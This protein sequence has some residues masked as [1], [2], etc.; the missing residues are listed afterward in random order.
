LELKPSCHA[1]DQGDDDLSA[2]NTARLAERRAARL[3]T[4]AHKKGYRPAMNALFLWTMNLVKPTAPDNAIRRYFAG[5]EKN[6]GKKFT[7][8]RAKF[9]RLLAAVA[10]DLKGY[11]PNY[12]LKSRDDAE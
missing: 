3:R 5:G 6:G 8:T 9:A 2:K 7:A 11:D 10:R 4:R 12:H 1:D